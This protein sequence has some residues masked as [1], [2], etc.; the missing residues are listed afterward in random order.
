MAAEKDLAFVNRVMSNPNSSDSAKAIAQ[1][2]ITKYGMSSDNA[3]S[4]SLSS[5]GTGNTA[6]SS[7][8]PKSIATTSSSSN[9]SNS[10]GI[11]NTNST[12]G[13]SNTSN[14]TSTQGNVPGSIPTETSSNNITTTPKQ[15]YG[16]VPTVPTFMD[17]GGNAPVTNYEKQN[18][19][20]QP[21]PVS[22]ENVSVGQGN[23]SYLVP[24]QLRQE[25]EN[26]G[27]KVDF[28]NGT[29]YAN[30]LPVDVNGLQLYN[31]SYMGT[32]QAIQN[33][34]NQVKAG[35]NPQTQTFSNNNYATLR[36]VFKNADVQWDAQ[37]G[38]TIEGVKIDT[39]N[40]PLINGKYYINQA[41]ADNIV[42][43]LND[44]NAVKVEDKTMFQ[45]SLESLGLNDLLSNMAKQSQGLQFMV[46][47]FSKQMTTS[48]MQ[49]QDQL[50]QNSQIINQAFAN[51]FSYD[52][53]NDKGLQ[54]ALK[55]A[56]N[57]LKQSLIGRGMLY[58]TQ[59]RDD[60]AQ[61]LSD[62]I[63]K[64]EEIAYERYTKNI[65]M[66]MQRAE[67]LGQLSQ[68]SFSAINTFANN[69]LSMTDKVNDN[70]LNSLKEMVTMADKTQAAQEAQ[71]K[72][73]LEKQKEE[74]TKALNRLNIK[75]YIETK[76][77]A[78]LLGLPQN[79]PSQKA[80]EAAQ[81]KIDDIDKAL[82]EASIRTQDRL[83]NYNK[84]TGA[85]QFQNDINNA[86][87]VNA[88]ALLA[89]MKATMPVSQWDKYIVQNKELIVDKLGNS[90]P[91]FFEAV[92]KMKQQS[93]D[94]YYKDQSNQRSWEANQR[95]AD[96][97]AR[98]GER[99]AFD[100][101]QAQEKKQKENTPGTSSSYVTGVNS[102]VKNII[103][104][105]KNSLA[106][107]EKEYFSKYMSA[108]RKQA[109]DK[110]KTYLFETDIPKDKVVDIL[111]QNGFTKNE[112]N[113]WL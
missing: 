93:L 15:G 34:Q 53:N 99:L 55:Y 112:I 92:Q 17:V 89:N 85:M 13:I 2:Y 29:V 77:D 38:V 36:D 102:T 107:D 51:G 90:F 24:K 106:I 45:Q 78:L 7:V 97:N 31:G 98:A 101:Q 108:E 47:D 73:T 65:Q 109:F 82:F 60:Y 61:I 105:Y 68:S 37:N 6:T 69:M 22:N 84:T 35:Y 26:A 57:K 43:Q 70:T 41:D 56:E 32:P 30:D 12:S 81:Q 74:Y 23:T 80:R 64:Y 18:N 100:K 14:T 95:S 46:D 87:K 96:A 63:P 71:D 4:Y 75:G 39:S 111:N 3:G 83:V 21:I 49:L 54:D 19:K 27:F 72:A 88:A 86:G 104:D 20:P 10:S 40:M 103:D 76:E 62:L 8:T 48:Y 91:D 59:G 50:K 16:N 66:Q 67:A 1:K 5:N 79:T 25:L 44:A 42:K 110:V 9:S 52:Q 113:K 58:S 28:K 11:S 33:V 94:N